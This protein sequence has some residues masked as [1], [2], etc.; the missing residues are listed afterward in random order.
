MTNLS[1][2]FRKH[3]H[4][5][6]FVSI[7]LSMLHRNVGCCSL[8]ESHID[9]MTIYFQNSSA[10]DHVNIARMFWKH[11]TKCLSVDSFLWSFFFEFFLYTGVTSSDLGQRAISR[12]KYN[13]LYFHKNTAQRI[14][15]LPLEFLWEYQILV[16]LYQWLDFLSFS[17]CHT[18]PKKRESFHRDYFFFK[19]W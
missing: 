4:Y 8:C 16:M 13:N 19:S 7:F 14:H 9:I 6:H 10:F 1:L 15:N 5:W 18:V 3:H 12:D 11:L 2:E 17:K